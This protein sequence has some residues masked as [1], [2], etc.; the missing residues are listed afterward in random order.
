MPPLLID[1]LAALAA[2]STLSAAAA[3]AAAAGVLHTQGA[4]RFPSMPGAAVFNPTNP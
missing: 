2:L 1:T 3:A 4:A